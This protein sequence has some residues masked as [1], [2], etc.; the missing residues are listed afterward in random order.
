[1]KDSETGPREG[2]DVL[3]QEIPEGF[4]AWRLVQTDPPTEADFQSHYELG[5]VPMRA[6]PSFALFGVSMFSE[7][8]KL[9]RMIR[10]RERRGQSSYCARIIFRPQEDDPMMLYGVYK[11]RT[12]H[13]EVFA[14]PQ[15]LLARVDHV[16]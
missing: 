10:T 3:L 9:D 6:F 15:D 13:L 8:S 5:R 7:R 16:E 4:E 11:A 2:T 1:M 12:A 14:P